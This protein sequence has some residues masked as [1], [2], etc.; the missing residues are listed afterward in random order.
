LIWLTDVVLG[1]EKPA[2]QIVFGGDRKVIEGDLVPV[3][4]PGARALV[5]DELGQR[6]R[7]MRARN[8]RRQRSNGMLCSLDELGWMSGGPN[9]VA[10]LRNVTVGQ[11]LDHLG[12][13][14]WPK[15][16]VDWDRAQE[17]SLGLMVDRAVPSAAALPTPALASSVGR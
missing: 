3:A 11:S 5:N 16:V 1:D 17:F 8:Y 6:T 9:E 10:I 15:V 4:P 2:L 12:A 13:E 7:K 14:D